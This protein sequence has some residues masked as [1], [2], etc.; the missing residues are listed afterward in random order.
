MF[1]TLC[2]TSKVFHYKKVLLTIPLPCRKKQKPILI[3]VLCQLMSECRNLSNT[4]IACKTHICKL[5][6]DTLR[7]CIFTELFLNSCLIVEELILG[8]ILLLRKSSLS[9]NFK[10]MDTTTDSK[11]IQNK[12]R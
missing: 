8:L 3:S 12:D 7:S 11:P 5:D 9:Q 1:I 10:T 4:K 6:Y 2:K